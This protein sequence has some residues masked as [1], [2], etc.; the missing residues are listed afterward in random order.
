[1]VNDIIEELLDL[2]MEPMLESLW[3][4]SSYKNED[5]AP[6]KVGR[7]ALDGVVRFL[8][9]RFHRDV[10][11]VQGAERK[12]CKG[13]GSWW[14]DRFICRSK[15]PCNGSINWSWSGAVLDKV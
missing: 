1:M 13:L 6:L 5:A 15:Y 4:A 10:K 8:S 9:N 11:G 2:D 12:M 3:W 14:R 7:L